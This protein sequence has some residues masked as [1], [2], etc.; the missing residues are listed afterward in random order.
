[1]NGNYPFSKKFLHIKMNKIFQCLKDVKPN[2]ST[3]F[4]KII[5]R[6]NLDE[7]TYILNLKRTQFKPNVININDIAHLW[8]IN[9]Y[10]QFI[11]DPYVVATYY[12]SYMMKIDK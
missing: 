6:L 9:T 12:M 7:N 8:S 4:K 11:L 10:I 1:M 2:E 3:S 5:T